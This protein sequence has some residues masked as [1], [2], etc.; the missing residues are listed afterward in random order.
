MNK[1]MITKAVVLVGVLVLSTVN[2]LAATFKDVSQTHW[3]YTNITDMQKRGIMLSNSAGEFLPNA[4][5]NFFETADVLAKATGYVDVNVNQNID[6]TFKQ[7]IIN[8]SAVQKPVIAV[9]ETKFTS[10]DKRYNEQIAYLLGRGYLQK[11]ELD[12]FVSKGADQKEV[13]PV[14][15][16]QELAVFIVRLLG[17][18]ETA[19]TTYTT[20]GFS[21]EALILQANKPH[22][23]YLKAIGLVNPDAKGLFNANAQVTRALCA[24][25]VGD[26]LTYK[27]KQTAASS[28]SKVTKIIPKGDTEHWIILEQNGKTDYYAIKN[29]TKVTDLS[30][31]EVAIASIPL[32][33]QA[34][35][36]I[37][38]ENNV[39]YITSMKLQSV[40]N[41]TGAANGAGTVTGTITRIG[42]NG[43]LALLLAD[44]STKNYF[45][46][47]NCIVM[48]GQESVTINELKLGDSVRATILSDTITKIEIQTGS[49]GSGIADL[50][51]GEVTAKT[52]RAEGHGLSLK[53][54]TR[55]TNIVI[56]RKVAVTRNN[57]QAA[58]GDI[59]I[60]DKIKIVRQE[61][62]IIEVIATG[63]K[64]TITGQVSSVYIA[65]VPQVTIKTSES[66]QTFII[67]DTTEI[68]DNNQRTEVALRDVRLG[69]NVELLIESKEVVS[70]VIQ[71]GTS[72]VRYAGVVQAIGSNIEYIDV[73]V[74][75]DPLT[76]T[77]RVIKRVKTSA[78][79]PIELRGKPEH[80]SL[81]DVGMGVVI[82]YKYLD[83]AVPEKVL[84]I[85]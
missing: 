32:E 58:F 56:D 84:I 7:Q 46:D 38:T 21:D 26:A 67:S 55:T 54:G 72:G 48:L 1:K 6:A 23:A 16:K 47:T 29:T 2:T 69:Q 65:A 3:A 79:V 76:E 75:Y 81:L 25:M 5:M 31:K 83:D 49:T 66:A 28:F 4:A 13:K 18:E 30:G 80:R 41:G 11:S 12:K 42:S 33:S 10:W 8:N 44:E 78:G 64:A 37:A 34:A 39:K 77:S 52:L 17:K 45:V 24:K 51:D 61:G 71:R 22:I 57:K 9:Y 60:G 53:Q 36:V 50:S 40:T 62:S 82:T 85:E 20:A 43:D 14:V 35:V 15:T 74:D 70:L 27:E 73:L 63:T 59:K 19:K 68:Y